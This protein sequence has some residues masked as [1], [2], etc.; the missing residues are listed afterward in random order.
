MRI[1]Y[2]PGQRALAAELRAYF[3]ELMTP[4][5]RAAL[6]S[7]GGEYGDGVAYKEIVRQLGK[8]G[9]L[10]LGWPP[11]YGGQGRSMLDQ[12]I[13]TDEAAVAGVPVPFLTVN[14]VGPTIMRYGTDEQKAFYLPKIAAGEL[15]FSIG[16]SEPEA[17]TDLASLR[18]RAERDGDEY[19]VTGQKMWT[20]LIE[21]ADYVWLAVRTDPAAKKHRGLSIL[22]VPTSADGFSWTK[23]H[24][25]AGAG[26]SATYY[27]N[28]RVPVSARVAGENAGWP[29]ITNQLNHER[30]ALTSSAPVRKALADVLAWAKETGA[31]DQEWVRLHLA[32]VH[33][34]AEYLKLRNWRIAWAAAASE[35]GPAEASATKVFGTEFAIEAYR[36][37]MEVLGAAA[38]VREG[39]PGALL[40]GRIER[41]HRSALI[42]TFGG[43]T[44]EIQRDMIAATALGL[45]V[46]R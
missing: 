8:D 32:R 26:T 14:T 4:E 42:L 24:T 43:G 13:F 35:L 7:G 37:L 18:T 28:V 25:V 2:T 11:E 12:L 20:S 46:T 21:Y 38:V 22:I 9:W 3:A 45:P 30:V 40:A 29:L 5:R 10:A 41:L 31:I 23:V 1:D 27:D 15:H 19:V 34:G 39:S 16:Y 36:L 6:R 17:G 33:A 44:N